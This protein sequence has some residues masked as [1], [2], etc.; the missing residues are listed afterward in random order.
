MRVKLPVVGPEPVGTNVTLTTQ[1]WNAS[2]LVSQVSVSAKSPA[3]AIPA[4]FTDAPP[5]LVTFTVWGGLVVPA[6]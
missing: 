3:T 5:A 1:V 4:I 6:L 2:S